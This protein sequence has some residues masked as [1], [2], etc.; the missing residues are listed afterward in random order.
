MGGR[1]GRQNN[2]RRLL[3][4]IHVRPPIQTSIAFVTTTRSQMFSIFDL[5]FDFCHQ[6]VKAPSS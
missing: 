1:N 4:F 2:S 6:V 5:V 3:A